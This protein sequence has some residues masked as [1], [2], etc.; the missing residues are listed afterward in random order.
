MFGGCEKAH[1]AGH[2]WMS[3]AWMGTG[4]GWRKPGSWSQH[5]SGQDISGELSSFLIA[6]AWPL[7]AGSSIASP[8]AHPA[9]TSAAF[10]WG[11]Y[12]RQCQRPYWSPGRKYPLFSPP[13]TRSVTE[14]MVWLL[15]FSVPV[16]V[17]SVEWISISFFLKSFLGSEV[18]TQSAVCSNTHHSNRNIISYIGIFIFFLLKNVQKIK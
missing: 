14:S 15:F 6:Q 1:R 3:F 4:K 13:S 11:S 5:S 18:G 7:P 17:F 16:L 2:N 9:H 12:G 8:S 10:L